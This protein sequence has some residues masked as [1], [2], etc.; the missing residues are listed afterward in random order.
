MSGFY[1]MY[2]YDG[3]PVD[4]ACLGRMREA[5][6]YYGP[7]GGGSR[8]AGPVGMGHLLLKVNPEDA[9]ERQP[10]QGERG[11]VVSAARLDNRDALL[12][13]LDVSASD[14]PQ[15][16][17]GQ[18]VGLAFDRWGE[19]ICTHLEGDWAFAAWDVERRRLFFGRD[20]LGRAALYYYEGKGYIA[21]ASSLK[22]LLALPG[23]PKEADLLRLAEILVAWHQSA[24]LTAYKGFRSVVGAHLMTFT[25]NGRTGDRRFWTPE[26]REPLRFKRDEEYVEGFLEHFDRAVRSCLRTR[27]P[28]AAEL[29]GGRDSGSV[30]TLAAPILASQGRDLIAFTSVPCFPPDGADKGRIGNEW[31]LAHATAMMAGSNLTHIPIYAKD[32]GIIAG[33]EHFLDMHD[34]PGH[35][36]SNYFWVQAIME[37][38]A[39]RGVGVLLLG[40]VGNLTVSF[41]GNGSVLRSLYKGELRTALQLVMHGEPDPLRLL[42]RQV[43][44]PLLTPAQWLGNRM[45]DRFRSPWQ[46]Y[47]ALNVEM[48]KRLDLDRRMR[49]AGYDPTFI[50]SG[51]LDLREYLYKPECGTTCSVLS[52]VNAWHRVTR[53]DPTANH[54]LLEFL[55][56]VPDE[57]FY[58]RG[59]RNYLF[60]RAFRDRMP[61]QVV[62]AR[63][64]GRQ[65][66][67]L[68]HRIVHEL[69]IFEDCIQ[70]LESVPEAREMLDLPLMRRCLAEVVAKVDADT[71]LNA[72]AILVRGI[73]VGLLLRRIAASRE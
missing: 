7:D 36:A 32:Y 3:A 4:P 12:K 62:F 55:L 71:H 1:G 61:A 63:E 9:F 8:I 68:G 18:L 13:V 26:G 56:R 25:S 65:A 73:G 21:F 44:N 30:V 31:D 47:S 54:S 27:R 70:S 5:M 66:A 41:R 23:T 67:D 43:V 40:E 10:V 22:A 72:A 50:F 57:Q 33:V 17:D 24:E 64:R 60:K 28:V 49:R 58:R 35:P 53:L 59:E 16:S 11:L 51:F 39:Q 34:G 14:A 19:D 48:A 42:K 6:G 46:E 15:T 52:E 69:P 20:I 38:C 2:R 29:S 45:K 37:A